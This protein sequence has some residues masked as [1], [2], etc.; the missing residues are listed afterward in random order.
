MLLD[1]LG[2]RTPQQQASSS[3][4]PGFTHSGK[5]PKTRKLSHPLAGEIIPW[6]QLGPDPNC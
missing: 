6:D 3:L 1:W 5:V 4:R 2:P